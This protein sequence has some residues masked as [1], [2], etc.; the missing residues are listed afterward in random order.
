ML[1]FS[2]LK[3]VTIYFIIVFLS[4]FSF[5]NF[6]E[7]EDSILLSIKLINEK[8]DKITMIEYIMNNLIL[9][10]YNTKYNYFFVSDLLNT[11]CIVD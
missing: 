6:I 2:K 3:I 8:K 1:Y 9:E 11:L 7:N 4:L 5:V 10:K